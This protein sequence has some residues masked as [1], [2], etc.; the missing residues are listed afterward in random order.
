MIAVSAA[1][2]IA[3]V[4]MVNFSGA[5][6]VKNEDAKPKHSIKD[7]MKK[8]MKGGLCKK[9]VSGKASDDEKKQLLAMFTA[10]AASKP[11]VGDADSWK[12]KT[13]ALVKAVNDGD[14]AALKKAANCAACHKAHKPKKKK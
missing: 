10:M 11:P 13:S 3:A 6:D 7:V 4:A 9:V 8:G 12:A 1:L 14:A 5:A 2:A